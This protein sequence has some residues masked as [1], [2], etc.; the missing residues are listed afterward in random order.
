VNPSVSGLELASVTA[1][2]LLLI[3]W[4]MGF[5]AFLGAAVTIA[6]IYFVR[7][8]LKQLD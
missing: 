3:I 7:S 5:A 2:P 4:S 8:T 6:V 1:A